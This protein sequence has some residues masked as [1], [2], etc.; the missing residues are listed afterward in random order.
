MKKKPLSLGT[1][2]LAFL[3]VVLLASSCQYITGEALT[4]VAEPE[5]TP[6]PSLDTNKSFLEASVSRLSIN[7]PA[8]VPPP[9]AYSHARMM[10]EFKIHNPN[11]EPVILEKFEYA[12]YGDGHT[13]AGAERM[14]SGEYPG[15]AIEPHATANL[16]FPLPY[17]SKDED[18]ALWSE[19][20]EGKVIW[21]IKGV[22]HICFSGDELEEFFECTVEDYSLQIDERCK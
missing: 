10:F 1:I 8:S 22:A 16:D 7:C 3:I 17:I 19:M 2:A 6:T 13:V 11:D 5:P 12:V 18:P 21:A 15:R 20:A 4:P 9:M 14:V